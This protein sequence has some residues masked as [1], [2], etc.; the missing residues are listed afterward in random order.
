MSRK[1]VKRAN[2]LL[3][4]RLWT[5]SF[6]FVCHLSTS[7]K[8]R[9]CTVTWNLKIFSWLLTTRLNLAI[10][11]FLKFSRTRWMSP[12]L[13]RE[14]HTT[15]RQRFASLN[16]MHILQTCGPS[17]VSC[18]NFARSSTLSN[19]KIYLVSSSRSFKTN[20]SRSLIHTQLIWEIWLT[21]CWTKMKRKDP[22]SLTFWECSL[23][24]IMPWS[25]LSHKVKTTWT[26]S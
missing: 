19:L 26:Q 3:K 2:G 7:I 25:S 13:C 12:W 21:W 5:G 8:E 22:K 14:L 15:C 16:H 23:C 6:R 17:V 9:S 11:A 4:L 20:K 24:R 1:S 18:T 10:S